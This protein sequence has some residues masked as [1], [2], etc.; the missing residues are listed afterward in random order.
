[1]TAPAPVQ[2]YVPPGID[3]QGPHIPAPAAI[4]QQ[5]AVA[6]QQA[7]QAAVPQATPAAVISAQGAAL[8]GRG[9]RVAHVRFGFDALVLIE[10]F[11]GSLAAM[12][13]ALESGESGPVFTNIARSIHT[14]LAHEFAWGGGSAERPYDGPG[15]R[16]LLEFLEPGRVNEYSAAVGTA[17]VESFGSLMSSGNDDGQAT[18]GA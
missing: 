10:E 18:A 9:G 8:V 16:E 13:Q 5:P 17:L 4:A 12:Q 15:W 2:P 6:P 3:V 7:P 11:F 14:G 1:M